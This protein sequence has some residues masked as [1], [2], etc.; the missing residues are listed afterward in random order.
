MKKK[1]KFFIILLI[2]TILISISL[3]L[4]SS[5]SN[6]KNNFKPSENDVFTI[7]EN[8]ITFKNNP[9]QKTNDIIPPTEKKIN[10]IGE[11]KL[12]KYYDYYH[13]TYLEIKN[14]KTS[15]NENIIKFIGINKPQTYDLYTNK[16]KL[17]SGRNLNLKEINSTSNKII[18][19]NNIAR[20]NNL[21]LNDNISIEL[22]YRSKSNSSEFG[23]KKETFK[24][25]GL[26]D[27]MANNKDKSITNNIY[28]SK[29]L[30]KK[31]FDDLQILSLNQFPHDISDIIDNSNGLFK[32]KNDIIQSIKN[33]KYFESIYIVSENDSIN[34][35]LSSTNAIKSSPYFKM[36]SKSDKFNFITKDIQYI[37][38]YSYIILLLSSI[39]L[40]SLIIFNLNILKSKHI[41]LS[42]IVIIIF[43]FFIGSHSSKEIAFELIYPNGRMEGHN[44]DIS[45]HNLEEDIDMY[46]FN[47]I[48]S[49]N[50]SLSDVYQEYHPN[51]LLIVFL[52]YA[53]LLII[54]F[55]F[56]L[57]AHIKIGKLRRLN[58][59]F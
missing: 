16:I 38:R 29:I 14:F 8:E 2:L 32:S 55:I 53:V 43:S 41:F 10:N 3:C 40:F 58:H 46:A 54:T 24:I 27:E 21:S 6:A 30:S 59:V 9:P 42:F 47:R 34:F 50:L 23:T 48:D 49:D 33:E 1:I 31:L 15:N 17:T 28:G 36:I 19:S 51:N 4:I 12:V 13:P 26:F 7:T 52:K 18:L 56:S 11:N 39:I 45:S 20:L 22:V 35:R 37:H 57:I 25:V 44:R 5:Y